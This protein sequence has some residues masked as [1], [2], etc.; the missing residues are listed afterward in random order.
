MIRFHYLVT[1]VICLLLSSSMS[2]QTGAYD[3]RLVTQKV[4]CQNNKVWMDLEIKASAEAEVFLLA[5]QNYRLT[6]DEAAIKNPKIA[7]ELA[8]SGLV[9][10]DDKKAF[11]APHTIV[12]TA[13]NLLSYNVFLQGGDGYPLEYDS[14]TS[15]GRLEFDIV[16]LEK[17]LK[18]TWHTRAKEH[19]P[20]SI[21]I[22]KAGEEYFLAKEGHYTEISD[23]FSNSC[24]PDRASL[25]RP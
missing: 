21:I 5:N 2:A 1:V 13:G 15:I 22:G 12:G 16:D 3:V 9:Q 14:W 19:F 11:F 10:K 20:N 18:A 24:D 8:V 7:E 4:D 6:Y 25:D 23:C 17:C